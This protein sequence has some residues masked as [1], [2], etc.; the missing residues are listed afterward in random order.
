MDRQTILAAVVLTT[1]LLCLAQS[2]LGW[3]TCDRSTAFY[4]TNN[5][6]LEWQCPTWEWK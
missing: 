3:L 1:A 4:A 2:S 6:V 5:G